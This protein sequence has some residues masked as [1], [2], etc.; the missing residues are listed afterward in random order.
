VAATPL[1]VPV[2]PARPGEAVVAHAPGVP[3]RDAPAAR[4][5][6]IVIPTVLSFA[7]VPEVSAGTALEPDS[8]IHCGVSAALT[9][10]ETGQLRVFAAFMIA[11]E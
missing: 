8:D 11:P 7:Q 1:L 5:I 3:T 10:N 2:A 6:E 4:Q 9:E